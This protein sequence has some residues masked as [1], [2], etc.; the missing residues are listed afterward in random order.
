MRARFVEDIAWSL[1]GVGWG[2]AA[3]A[4]W[5]CLPV[6]RTQAPVWAV[7]LVGI[8]ALC[9]GEMTF[10]VLSKPITR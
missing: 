7:L 9:V 10:R 2:C 1:R 8:L 4:L 3:I 5:S 6:S